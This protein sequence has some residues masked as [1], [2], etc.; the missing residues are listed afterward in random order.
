MPRAAA[1]VVLTRPGPDGLEV[2]L[3]RRPLTMAFAPGL[4]AFPGGAVDPD[5]AD[6]ALLA[7]LD[8]ETAGPDHVA[9]LRELFEEAGILL[10][11][12]V[13]PAGAARGTDPAQVAAARSA[14]LAGRVA[15]GQVCTDLGIR[16]RA[17][18]LL[19]LSRWVTPPIMPRRFDARFF[20]A[21]LPDGADPTFEGDE[22]AGHRWLTPRAAL[23]GLADGSIPMWMP[24]STNLQRLL[25]VRSLAEDGPILRSN[26]AG[27]PETQ[28]VAP[29][30]VRIAQP[31]G[32]GVDGLVVH[33]YLVGGRELVAIDAGDPSEEA[34]LAIA[35]AATAIGGTIGTVALTAGDPDHAGGAEHLREGLSVSVHGGIGAGRDLPFPLVELSDGTPVPAGDIRVLAVA[36]PGPRD[37]HTVYWLAT[38]R[39]AVVGDLVG[40]PASHS[41]PGP[42]D[43]E[44]WRA[45]LE[46]LRWLAPER[47][48]PAHGEPVEGADAVE[49]AIAA[50]EAALA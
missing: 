40:P 3:T 36:A 31:S 14:L 20:A 17:S 8:D 12:P 19:P 13:G 34:L 38:S 11:E 35:E 22:V 27:P 50:A 29:D 44:A 43:R 48:L 10:A 39:T 32:A 7:R 6:P 23:D 28:E 30:V 49:S 5:D 33:A 47:L 24:T 42:P 9:A 46:R 45:S 21:A 1:T 16:L 25:H 4:H 15:F 41:I 26:E 18:S 2:L 37:D